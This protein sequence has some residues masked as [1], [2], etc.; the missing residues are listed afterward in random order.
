MAT[1]YGYDGNYLNSIIDLADG[2]L[3]LDLDSGPLIES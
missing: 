3:V 1:D 2:E